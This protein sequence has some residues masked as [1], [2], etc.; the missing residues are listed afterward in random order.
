MNLPNPT[1]LVQGELPEVT[2]P[3][4]DREF[5]VAACWCMWGA[6]SQA[7]ATDHCNKKLASLYDVAREVMIR[8]GQLPDP[9]APG[10]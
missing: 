3:A 5:L 1:V 8:A 9:C 6:I 2:F 10:K 4:D 7:W